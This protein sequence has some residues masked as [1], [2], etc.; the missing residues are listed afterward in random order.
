MTFDD[1]AEL[2]DRMRPTYPA[3]L[4]ADLVG[5]TGLNGNSR[6]LEIGCGTGQATVPLAHL[7]GTL[8]A[9]EPGARLAEVARRNLAEQPNARVVEA[10]FEEW[11]APD[12]EFDLLLSATAFH[13]VDPDVRMI[14]S[15]KTLRPG[16]S[17]AIIST[18]HVAGGT[19]GFFDEV[20][21]C[22]ERFDPSTPPGLRL[23]P[24]DDITDDPNEFDESG[25]FGS[26]EFRRYDLQRT[27]TTDEY[28]DLLSTYSGHMA[29]PEAQRG[30]LLH[31][32]ATVANSSYGGEV[33]KRYLTRLALAHTRPA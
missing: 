13:W 9:L 19:S 18:H 12:G 4:F 29:M 17:L 7:V 20:Q 15:T 23:T 16:G 31:C 22:Y 30:A 33:T 21:E 1:D 27:Y 5:L 6:V 10:T 11:P 32:I 3:Q 8:V 14:K 26:V 28:R 24:G 25:R 2:Y